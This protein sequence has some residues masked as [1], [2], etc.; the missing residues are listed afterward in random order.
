MPTTQAPPAEMKSISPTQF[1]E[2]FKA[3]D[4]AILIDV[5]TRE[6]FAEEHLAGSINIPLCGRFKKKMTEAYT[7]HQRIYITCKTGGRARKAISF[8]DGTGFANLVRVAGGLDQF[9]KENIYL[10]KPS[11]IEETVKKQVNKKLLFA[12]VALIIVGAGILAVS[13]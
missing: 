9:R 2:R 5:R 13:S 8:L 7:K 3:E 4:D 10:T 12:G 1:I 6:E 11:Q